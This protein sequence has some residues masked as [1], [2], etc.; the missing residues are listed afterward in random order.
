MPSLYPSKSTLRRTPGKFRGRRNKARHASHFNFFRP[1]PTRTEIDG[2]VA[3]SANQFQVDPDLVQAIIK[4]ESGYNTNAH[5][6]KG[7]RGLMQLIP[8]TARRFGVKNA[9]NPG[10]NIAGGVAYLKHLLTLF[11]GNVPLSVA[12][13]NAGEFAVLRRAGIPDYPETVDYVRK[14][15]TLYKPGTF[16]TLIPLLVT[17]PVAE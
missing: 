5:S 17:D 2:L 12:A 15:T 14:V 6:Q 10:Q 4:V 9:F 7:A 8:D 13:Y 1:A 16:D 3:G 11:S